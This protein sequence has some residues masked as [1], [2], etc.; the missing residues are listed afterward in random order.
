LEQSRPIEC[1]DA[2]LLATKSIQLR[3]EFYLL[4]DR[5]HKANMTNLRQAVVVLAEPNRIPID[6]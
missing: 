2:G 6:I 1:S 5:Q 4:R 3:F